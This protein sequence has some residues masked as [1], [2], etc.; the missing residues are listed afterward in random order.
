MQRYGEFSLFQMFD[1]KR[2]KKRNKSKPASTQHKDYQYSRLKK[3]FYFFLN[4]SK[5]TKKPDTIP[6]NR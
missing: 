1:R 2:S 3:V 4:K 6:S 5:K